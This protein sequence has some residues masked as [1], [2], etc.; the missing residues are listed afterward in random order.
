[1][2]APR[3]RHAFSL[4]ELLAALAVVAILAS[5]VTVGLNKAREKAQLVSCV[6]RERTLGAALQAYSLDNQLELLRPRN[7]A[8]QRW[9]ILLKAYLGFE[10]LPTGKLYKQ[11]TLKDPSQEAFSSD[12]PGIFGYNVE[13]EATAGD[14]RPIKLESLTRP[15]R[16]PLLATSDAEDGG[17]LR[18]QPYGPP[19]KALRMGYTGP[20]NRFGPAPNYGSKAVFL[21]ADWHVEA[22]E[23]CDNNAWPWNDP[24]AFAVR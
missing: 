7:E 16:F 13:L 19:P 21:F 5:L 2:P 9:P 8:T 1:M 24:E 3:P 6:G 20:T 4:I 22:V 11:P 18:L 14:D 23:V 17:G 15:D 10:D 12:A